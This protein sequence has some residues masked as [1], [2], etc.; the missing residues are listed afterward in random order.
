MSSASHDCAPLH[1][2][3]GVSVSHAAASKLVHCDVL[4]GLARHCRGDWGDLDDRSCEW[5]DI[6]ANCGYGVVSMYTDRNLNQFLV[7]TTPERD[8]TIVLLPHEY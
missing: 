7:M 4:K 3:D 2:M 8:Q 6:A 1:D 5:N